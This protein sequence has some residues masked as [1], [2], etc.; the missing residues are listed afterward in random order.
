MADLAP[1]GLRAKLA[2]A[3]VLMAA[4]PLAMLVL[5]AAWFA[6]PAVRATYQLERLFPLIQS[7]DAVWW[8]L[9]LIG[10]TALIAW[11]G[12][13]YLAGTIVRP[14]IQI[15]RAAGQMAGGQ[16]P[17]MLPATD[18][19]ELGALTGA[20]K[21]LTGQ[22]RQDM[23]QLREFG[24]RTTTINQQIQR[25][26]LCLSGLLQ[27]GELISHG[28]AVTV[29]LDL[30][31]QQAA[32]WFGRDGFS[33]LI[34]TPTDDLPMSYRRACG[35]DAGRLGAWTGP[36]PTPVVID[37]EHQPPP[38]LRALWSGLGQPSLVLHPVMLHGAVV[39]VLGV[40]LRPL[41]VVWPSELIDMAALLAKHAS[42]AM[43]NELLLK[44]TRQLSV[45]DELTGVY[46]EM[47]MRQRLE[48][49]I[50][51][52]VLYQRPCAY[53]LFS[54][55]RLAEVRQRHG[56]PEAERLLKQAARLVFDAVSEV[57]RVG[58]VNGSQL[59][60][61]L[62]ER[63]K[64]EAMEIVENLRHRME[65]MLAES[66]TSPDLLKVSCGLAENPVDGNTA[67]QLMGKA[68][69]GVLPAGMELPQH[70]LASP[71]KPLRGRGA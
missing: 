46:N 57:D 40:G 10:L 30:V 64:R 52:A 11:L 55:D 62:P 60:V 50:R 15:S 61:L 33:L 49:E 51:R 29:V 27:L 24:E 48:E 59:A 37:G 7:T 19:D 16:P 21:Q 17:T 66:G 35:I 34:V 54:I 36:C 4:V 3:C 25:R 6:L 70:L 26:M 47:Y 8:L 5:V 18:A 53:A 56:E 43:E 71:G 63:S 45:R 14:I 68:L 2:L 42:I 1:K 31:V 12:T 28:A 67:E 58:R 65:R 23:T 69:S 39:G 20:L 44:T 32:E 38:A 13:V 41:E 9:I 22:I